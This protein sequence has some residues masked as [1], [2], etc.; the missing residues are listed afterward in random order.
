MSTLTYQCP[1]CAAPL[2]YSGAKGQLA[3]QSCGNSFDPEDIA[4][5]GDAGQSSEIEFAL[6]TERFD[7][8]DS[9]GIKGF[10]CRNCGAELMT[11]DTTTATQC[12]YCG[13]PAVLPGQIEGSTKPEKV[14]PFRISK[15]QAA[16][17]FDQYFHGK[18]LLPNVFLNTR[19]RIDDMR[20][21]YVPYWLF[22]CDASADIWFDAQ[23]TRVS[24]EG[25]WEV[26]R[27][28]HYLVRRSGSLGFDGIPVDGSAK[29]DDKIGE[30]LEPY[31]VGEAVPFQPAVLAGAMADR[32]DV[33]AEQ[34][35]ARAIERVER[36]I[37]KELTD[38]VQGYS[39][40]S[41]RRKNIRAS[42]GRITPVLM[43]VWLMTT[44]KREKGETR[45]YTFAVN[46]QTGE[47]TCDVPCD[48]GKAALWFLA[49]F[50][51]VFAVGYGALVALHAM[52][53]IG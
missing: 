22:D 33:D 25:D 27:T 2:N 51:G 15:E 35:Q 28:R 26:R 21:L 52:G 9:Q 10:T 24:R 14:V 3:C 19:N 12:G 11:D 39:S 44:Q 32:A 40:V 8:Q 29:L 53:V 17:F 50:A 7:A 16:A 42:G 13:S 43:P 45:T 23:K 46:G 47:L 49:L 4:A 48:K 38:T 31:D 36:S 20:K 37:E 41:V 34:C 6:P 18:K 5:L 30:S 1:S